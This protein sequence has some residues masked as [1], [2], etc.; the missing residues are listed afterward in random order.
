MSLKREV[1]SQKL[2]LVYW[3]IRGMAQP[4]RHLL[5]LLCLPYE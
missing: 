3:N 2:Q 5:E 1:D 4:I